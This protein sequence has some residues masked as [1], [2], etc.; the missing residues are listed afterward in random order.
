MKILPKVASERLK[1]IIIYSLSIFLI[2]KIMKTTLWKIKGFFFNAKIMSLDPYT[3]HHT[4]KLTG[5][6]WINEPKCLN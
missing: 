4:Q 2:K 6:K 1:S 3:S 5:K